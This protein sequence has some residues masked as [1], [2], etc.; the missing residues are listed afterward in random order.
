MVQAQPYP[1]PSYADPGQPAANQ[2]AQAATMYD[3]QRVR[4]NGV[5]QGSPEPQQTYQLNEARPAVTAQT[6]YYPAA[7]PQPPSA[8]ATSPYPSHQYVNRPYQ[9]PP[10]A[11]A[12]APVTTSL[13]PPP[14]AMPL[15]TRAG[16]E[17]GVQGSYY[18]YRESGL[19]VTRA[20][21]NA[22]F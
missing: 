16:L 22:W 15:G 6:R 8:Y 1:A 19:D 3:P 11:V 12:N 17:V 5:V 7:S 18:R 4:S 20:W 14:P 13:A 10:A 21:G 9:A 2:A